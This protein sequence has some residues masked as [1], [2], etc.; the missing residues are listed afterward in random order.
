MSSSH[1]HILPLALG[2]LAT[3]TQPQLLQPSFPPWL[4]FLKLSLLQFLE[5]ALSWGE[6]HLGVLL[7]SSC[8]TQLIRDLCLD[9]QAHPIP[10]TAAH[11]VPSLPVPW[12]CS[13]LSLLP[14]SPSLSAQDPT[15]TPG[16][17]GNQNSSFSFLNFCSAL[18]KFLSG[19][20]LPAGY[21]LAWTIERSWN[22]LKAFRKVIPLVQFECIFST[23]YVYICVYVCIHTHTN[24]YVYIY[25]YTYTCTYIYI[26]IYIYLLPL[27]LIF[28]PKKLLA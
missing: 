10:R 14:W 17:F 26:Y 12:V 27:S 8:P 20:W 28:P 15:G 11:T 3:T 19:T 7:G 23:R 25:T 6:R 18:L 2:P 24:M 1:G 5:T 16:S 9:I 13:S 4:C 22:I 21:H